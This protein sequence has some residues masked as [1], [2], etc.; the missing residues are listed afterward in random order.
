MLNE[1]IEYPV[2]GDDWLPTVLVGGG[3]WLATA[4]VG[5]VAAAV[6]AFAFAFAFLIVTVPVGLVFLALGL[7]P[8]VLLVGYS[9]SVSRSVADGRE[10]PPGFDDWGQYARDGLYAFA[11]SL[12][13]GLPLVVLGVLATL[14]FGVAVTLDGDFA[15]LLVGLLGI[16]LALVSLILGLAYAYLLPA[17]LVNFARTDRV[18]A[19]WDVD[20]VRAIVLTDDYAVAWGLGAIIWILGNAVG[21]ALAFLLVGF[22]AYFYAQVAVTYLVTRGSID[23]LGLEAPALEPAAAEALGPARAAD[24]PADGEPSGGATADG[25]TAGG[26][27]G[28]EDVGGV[29]PATAERLRAAGFETVADLRAASEADLV[30][31]EGIGPGLAERIKDDV[32]PAP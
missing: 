2:A 18:G 9:V 28:L 17:A 25:A 31:V 29:G 13:Y 19:A 23:A 22:A 27:G 26:D 21:D 3:L 6:V 14:G 16:P 24:A 8:Y 15:G 30:E 12:V 4:I 1:A 20:E 7:V 32:G 5:V 10:R 11:I